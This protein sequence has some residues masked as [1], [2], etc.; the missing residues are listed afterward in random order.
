MI[1][2]Q[3][4]THPIHP[5]QC[6]H[7]TGGYTNAVHD[8]Q[9]WSCP[10]GSVRIMA[11]EWNTAQHDQEAGNAG[12]GPPAWNSDKPAGNREGYPQIKFGESWKG[13]C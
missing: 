4:K 6:E 2:S 7:G 1:K 13:E 12:W 11:P 10:H 5:M 8:S 3:R 9:K